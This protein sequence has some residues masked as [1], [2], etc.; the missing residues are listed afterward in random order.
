MRKKEHVPSLVTLSLVVKVMSQVFALLVLVTLKSL[1]LPLKHPTSAKPTA[2]PKP[3]LAHLLLHLMALTAPQLMLL[4]GKVSVSAELAPES[5]L[6]SVKNSHFKIL[7]VL[8]NL[9]V[10]FAILITSIQMA[11]NV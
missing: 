7:A 1:Y 2:A 6:V 8:E 3:E 5:S 10:L 4:N 11:K 9:M